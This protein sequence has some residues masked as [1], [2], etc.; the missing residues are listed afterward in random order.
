MQKATTGKPRGTQPHQQHAVRNWGNWNRIGAA[1]CRNQPVACS[2]NN[3]TGYPQ[4]RTRSTHT[5]TNGRAQDEKQRK[6]QEVARRCLRARLETNA[7]REYPRQPTKPCR[8]AP[9]QTPGVEWVGI[10][11]S[12]GVQPTDNSIR[13]RVKCKW[14]GRRRGGTAGQS[15]SVS[16]GYT[17]DKHTPLHASTFGAS[18]TTTQDAF[19]TTGK[20]R[21]GKGD[22]K[23]AHTREGNPYGIPPLADGAG[24]GCGDG[25]SPE[26]P[27]MPLPR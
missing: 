11:D 12:R 8:G 19:G 18:A 3:V 16:Q 21:R 27:G 14:R 22:S 4:A 7:V 15:H 13:N 17:E 5:Q 20:H 25:T 10:Q 9:I 1:T 26:L 23:P 6:M 24:N 2:Q